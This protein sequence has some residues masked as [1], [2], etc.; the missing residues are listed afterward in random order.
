PE[1]PARD[2]GPASYSRYGPDPSLVARDDRLTLFRD[3]LLSCRRLT[4][5]GL[6]RSRRLRCRTCIAGLRD[7][8][9]SRFLLRRRRDRAARL[10]D[11][12]V[13]IDRA[14]RAELR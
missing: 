10:A 9:R 12:L 14:V 4:C 5:R 8:R 13:P 7:F 3:R 2:L 1:Q 11:R 6:L